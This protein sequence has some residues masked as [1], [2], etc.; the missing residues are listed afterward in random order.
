ML[1][2]LPIDSTPSKREHYEKF[3]VLFDKWEFFNGS[4]TWKNHDFVKALAASYSLD[5]GRELADKHRLPAPTHGRIIGTGGSD[6]HA[7]RHGGTAYTQAA[8]VT[9]YKEFLN[10]I[11]QG[12]ISYD[13]KIQTMLPFAHSIYD[14][15]GKHYGFGQRVI[16]HKVKDK[17]T[18][19]LA[20][21]Y[22]GPV[23]K[24]SLP[25][26]KDSYSTEQLGRDLDYVV[27]KSMKKIIKRIKS[28]RGL[29]ML[30][31]GVYEIINTAIT[32]G[33]LFSSAAYK[34][35]FNRTLPK[36]DDFFPVVG[37]QGPTRVALIGDNMHENHGVSMRVR[38]LLNH[39]QGKNHVLVPLTCSD[40]PTDQIRVIPSMHKFELPVYK[41]QYL[42]VPSVTQLLQTFE[43]EQ[44]EMVHV[45]TP[46]TL[47]LAALGAAKLTGL[48]VVGSYH[49]DLTDYIRHYHNNPIY[50]QIFEKVQTWFY[51]QCDLV[52]ALSNHSRNY[53]VEA[54][55]KEAKIQIM[56]TGVDHKIF[57]PTMKND[58]IRRQI[59]PE[60][61]FMIL[62]A[63]RLE[64]EKN[65]NPSLY[66]HHSTFRRHCY[67]SPQ[68]IKEHH[69]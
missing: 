31:G 10:K 49:T 36:P 20:R 21:M 9:N 22:V 52:F 64:R 43:Q 7:K 60:N 3:M 29:D 16:I 8:G 62:F 57:N 30:K 27:V 48:P 53:L 45:L 47:G 19:S 35:H 34:F 14:L 24:F 63:G 18:R 23:K 12:D 46:G 67:Y 17:V 33:P 26:Y 4:R 68:E 50:S 2:N 54:G 56:Q 65:T 37:K 38:E 25:T 58:D 61:K 40:H 55:V 66:H 69:A 44:I 1:L 28:R 41:G 59:N 13:G 11:R 5:K 32:L 15:L 42:H 51:N 39:S 6:A